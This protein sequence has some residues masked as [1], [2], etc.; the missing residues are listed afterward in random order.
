MLA[1]GNGSNTKATKTNDCSIFKNSY[2][3]NNTLF[4]RFGSLVDKQFAI[5]LGLMMMV[6]VGFGQTV[7]TGD[8]RTNASGATFNSA[9][10]W[11]YYNGS[12]WVTATSASKPAPAA[13]GGTAAASTTLATSGSITLNVSA[14]SSSSG[15]TQNSIASA[16]GS[17]SKIFLSAANANIVAGLPVTGTN[18]PANSYVTAYSSSDPSI[19]VSTTISTNT[20]TASTVLTFG[21]QLGGNTTIQLSTNAVTAG[22]LVGM[23][24]GGSSVANTSYVTAINVAGNPNCI[25][26]SSAPSN[27]GV[28]GANTLTCF[29]S[30]T[31]CTSICVASN[32]S[33]VAG[34]LV[35]GAN[36]PAGAKVVSTSGS[37]GVILSLP[38]FASNSSAS[39]VN[40]YTVVTPITNVFINHNTTIDASTTSLIS[41]LWINNTSDVY[42]SGSVPPSN[43]TLTIGTSTTPML[44]NLGT[45]N[46]ASSA[47]IVVNSG[48]VATHSMAINST[49]TPV[50]NAGSI[51]LY[52]A[53]NKKCQI[54]FAGSG[55]QTIS[56]TGTSLILSDL[57][58]ANG[59][60][61]VAPSTMNIAGTTFTNNGTFTHNSSS[62]TFS[63]AVTTFTGA[64][65]TFNNITI[66][67]GATFTH[68]SVG[69]SIIG[70]VVNNGTFSASSATTT[71]SGTTA[72]TTT[73]SPTFNFNSLL[74]SGSLTAYSGIM[75]ISGAFT[76]NGT[77]TNNSGTI[78]FTG[79]SANN[80]A[81]SMTGTNAFNNVNINASNTYT[82]TSAADINGNL[83][84]T[85]ASSI[86]KAPTSVLTLKGNLT[87]TTSGTFTHNS[88]TVTFSPSTTSIV[89]GGNFAFN[90]LNINS[91]TIT[92]N[93][94]T[95][96]A[97]VTTVASGATLA[98]S[99]G[100]TFTGGSSIAGS[101]QINS[102]GSLSSVPTYTGANSTLIYNTGGSYGTSNEW[103][104]GASAGVAVGAGIP[105]NVSIQTTGTVVTL[106]GGRGI[107]GT[108]TVNSSCGM[109]LNA[110]SGDLYIGGDLVNNGSTWTNNS[111]AVFF[112]GSGTQ[113]IHSGSGTQFFDYL[114]LN[115]TGTVRDSTTTNIQINTTSGN[116][117][118]LLN[119]GSLDLNGK[120]LTLANNGGNIYT[121]GSSRTITSNIAGGVLAITGTK[122][123]VN[124]SGVG[125]L[126][127]GSNLS[128]NLTSGLDFGSGLSTVNGTVNLLSGGYVN[129]N[130]PT[131]GSASTLA[132]NSGSSYGVGS[133]W[134]A[135]ALSGAGVPQNVTIGSTIASS[136]LNFGS[137]T[138]Y[139]QA[140]GNVTIS[141]AT[142]GSYLTLS[143]AGGGDLYVGGNFTNNGTFTHNSRGVNVNGSSNVTAQTISGTFNGSGATNCIPYLTINTTGSAGVTLGSPVNVTN[144]LTLTA[145]IV[146]TTASNILTVVGNSTTAIS[147][148]S[149]TAFVNGPLAWTAT[150][151]SGNYKFPIGQG[152]ST[153]NYYPITLGSPNTGGS[154]ITLTAESFSTGSATGG[155]VDGT[156]ASVNN[157]YWKLVSSSALT[158][159]GTVLLASNNVT[160]S[161]VVA[162]GNA[163]TYTTKGGSYSA[164]TVLSTGTLPTSTTQYYS[165]GLLPTFSMGSIV[166][167]AIAGV[168]QSNST[169]Y[170]GQTI[171]ISGFGFNSPT[172]TLTIGGVSISVNVTSNTSLTFVV[173][174]TVASGTLILSQSGT[175]LSQ[176]FSVLGYV[177]IA[178]GDWNTSSTWSADN[179]TSYIPVASSAVIVN[180]AV[181][182]TGTVTNAPS[183]I[184]IN[185]TKSLVFSSTGTLTTTTL[186]NN[187]TLTL[188]ASGTT[189]NIAAGGTLTNN[190]T[191]TSTAGLVNFLGAGTVNGSSATTFYNLTINT[192]TLTL[193][194]V[195]TINGTFTINGGSVSASPIYGAFSTLNYNVAYNRYLE[196]NAT[197]A[198]TIGTTAGYPNNV[199]ISTGTFGLAN[200]SGG[201]SRAL[202]GTLTVNSGCTFDMTGMSVSTTIAGGVSIAS[203]GT[204]TMSA[205]AGGDV[206]IGGNFSNSGTF[207]NNSRLVTLNGSS[208]QTVTGATTFAYLTISNA[209]GVS[210]ASSIIVNNTLILSS[211]AVS[212]NGQTINI[213]ASG[214]ITN[215]GGSL[216]TTG[217]GGADGGTINFVGAATLN[218]STATT[219]YNATLN[220]GALTISTVPTING[221]FTINGGNVTAAPKYASSSTLTYG[222]TYTRYLEWSATGIGIIGTTAGYPNNVTVASG[223]FTVVNGDAGTARA[224]AGSLS[225]ASGATFTTGALNAVFTVG[226]N[227]TTTGSGS[228]NLSS[229]S[230]PVTVVGSVNIS[231]TGALTLSSVSGG[232]LN[233]ATDWTN[234]GTFTSNGRTVSFNGA[235]NSTINSA[236]TFDYLTVSKSNGTAIVSL[237]A[238]CT[239]NQ[240]LTLTQGKLDYSTYTLTLAG[241][242]AVGT[243]T[244]VT[245]SAGNI[246]MT[247]N[248]NIPALTLGNL[249]IGGSSNTVTATGALTFATGT[250]LTVSTNN[251]LDMSTFTMAIGA[252]FTNSGTGTIQTKGI[253]PASQTWSG[254]VKYYTT[255]GGQ[256]VYSG[257]YNNLLLTNT[258]GTQT[259]NGAITV[260]G[261]LTTSS[262]G[263]FDMSTN[264]LTG[265]GSFA[266]TN[267]GTIKTSCLTATSSSP[268]P[269]VTYSSG[270]VTYSAATGAQTVVGTTYN[271]L[272]ISNTSGTQSAGGAIIVTGN[273]TLPTSTGTFDVTSANNYPISVAGNWVGSTAA[274]FTAQAGAVTFNGAGIQTISG[275]N[276][277][278]NLTDQVVAGTLKFTSGTTQTILNG[279]TL[280]LAGNGSSGN[281]N[282]LTVTSST[283]SSVANIT[284]AGTPITAISNCNISWI[285]NTSAA[286]TASSSTNSGNNTNI[287]FGNGLYWIGGTGT[288]AVGSF[289]T[290]SGGA[291]CG[292][293]PGAGDI[294]NFDVNSGS[295]PTITLSSALTVGALNFTNLNVTFAGAF[296]ITTT[297]MSVDGCHPTFVD[298][299][300]I[301]SSLTF[302]NSG[303]LYYAASGAGK[304]F[305]LG[306]GNSFTLTGNTTTSYFDGNTNSYWNYNT[307]SPLTLYFNPTTPTVGNFTVTKGNITLGN[308]LK[309]GRL[310]LS[311]TNSQQLI[312]SSGVTFTCTAG[313]T[314]SLATSGTANAGVI[315]ASASGST[316]AITGTNSTICGSA[317]TSYVLF[318]ANTIVNNFQLNNGGA[319]F[320][321]GLANGATTV[322]FNNLLLTAGIVNNST[323]NITIANNGTITRTAGT[324]SAAPIYG[325]TNSSDR[326]NVT[327]AGS[328]TTGLE[329]NGSNGSI[330]TF[331]VND[332]ITTTLLAGSSL[333]VDAV[334]VGGGTSGILTYP[335][336]TTVTGLTVN[337]AVTVNAG[338][339][340]TCGTQTS[341]VLHTLSVNGAIANAGTFDMTGNNANIANAVNVTLNGTSANQSIGGIGTTKFNTLTLNNSFSSPGA[342]LAGAVTINNVLALGSN[343]LTVGANTLTFGTT[344]SAP[345]LSSGGM[346]ASNGSAT[347]SFTNTSPITFPA[348]LFTSNV[349]NLTLNGI[350][351]VTLGS[352]TTVA[353]TLTVNA[354]NTLDCSTYQLIGGG[355]FAVTNSGTIKTSN[356][357]STPI[358][359]GYTYGGTVQFALTTGGQTIPSATYTNLTLSNASG[360]NT[361]NGTI[362]SSGTLTTTAGGTFDMTTYDLGVASITNNGTIITSSTSASPLTIGKTWAGTVTYASLS[363]GQTVSNGTYST[364][365]LNN[366]SGTNI[367]TSGAVNATTLTTTAGGTW[368]L[369]TAST[370][371][372]TLSSITNNGTIKTAV[373]TT[374]SATPIAIGKNYGAVGTIEF[375]GSAAQTLPTNSATYYY[376]LTINNTAANVT[377]TSGTTLTVNGVLTIST[378]AYLDVVTTTFA[379][380]AGFSNS[381]L[382]TLATQNTSASAA[383]PVGKT[384]YGNVL[385]NASTT[386]QSIVA[387]NYNNLDISGATTGNRTLINGATISISGNYT[388]PTGSG[389]MTTTGSTVIFNGNSAQTISNTATFNN[390]TINQ[391]THST[392]SL[393][394]NGTVTGTLTLT[395]GNV[396]T[397]ANTL[398]FT[399][400]SGGSSSAFV[401]GNLLRTVSSGTTYTFPVG[402]NTASKYYQTQLKPSFASGTTTINVNA[403][404]GATGSAQQG[405]SSNE[406]W[407]VTANNASS[408]VSL[409][410]LALQTPDLGTNGNIMNGTSLT[411][412]SYSL[413]GGTL[414]VS[415][416]TVTAT[417]PSAVSLTNGT[418]NYFV[419]TA[420][421]YYWVGGSGTW[422]SG[423]FSYTS[424][425]ASCAC[426]PTA[427]TDS[428]VFD[429]NSGTAPITV[430]M[431]S[432]LNFRGLNV[433]VTPAAGG[434]VIFSNP[435][436]TYYTIVDTNL[437]INNSQL[438]FVLNGPA[439]TGINVT[440][441]KNIN[442]QGSN[443]SLIYASSNNG[444]KLQFGDGTN[445]FNIT[446]PTSGA[447]GF[448][449][450][451]STGKAAINYSATNAQ[452]IYFNATRPVVYGIMVIK[453]NLILGSNVR[454]AS[455][456]LTSTNNQLLVV[457]SGVTLDLAATNTNAFTA[458]TNGGLID[459]RNGTVLI[460][461]SS[462]T[463]INNSANMFYT[464]VVDSLNLT[465]GTANT[466]VPLQALT[467]NKLALTTGNYNNTTNNISIPTNKTVTIDQGSFTAAPTYGSSVNL[468]YISSSGSSVTTNGNEIPATSSVLN[469][470]SVNA[471]GSSKTIILGAAPTI[472]GILTVNSGNTLDFSANALN[473]GNSATITN[474]GTIKTSNTSA[475]PIPAGITYGGTVQF[476]LA[477]GG[478]TIPVNN[479]NNLTFSNTSG[480]NTANGAITSSGTLT[481][482][483]GGTLDM[484]SYDLGVTTI[485]N[486]GT[487]KTSSTTATA[488]TSGKTWGGTVQFALTTGGQTIPTGAFNN[489]TLS[490]TS[491]TNTASGAITSSGTLTTTAGGTLEMS[492]YDLG[493]A[494][495][496]NNGTI[497]T[498]STSST[499]LTTGKSWGGTVQ[500]ASTSGGQTIALG[501]YTTLTLSNTSGTNTSSGGAVNATTLNTTAGG[502]WD[503]GSTGTLGGTL[504]S[505]THNG[506]LKS[507][508][509]STPIANNKTYGGTGTIEFN[510]TSAQVFTAS[511]S[512]QV[513]NLIV[514][515]TSGLTLT[516][517]LT[518]NGTLTIN[519]NC[520]FNLQSN[521][522]VAGSSFATSI[523]G[524]LQT[525]ASLPTGQTWGGTVQYNGATSNQSIVAGTYNN[526]DIS[527]G[528]TGNRTLVNGAT[529]TISGNYTANTGSG[530]LTTTGSTVVF[531]GSNA[532]SITNPTSFNNLTINK[533]GTA[534]ALT[535]NSRVNIGT[536][537]TGVL[538]LTS[539]RVLTTSINT[540]TLCDTI[541][542]TALVGG[543]SSAYIDGPFRRIARAGSTSYIFPVGN[544][545][546]GDNYFVDTLTSINITDTI[547]VT[548]VLSNSGSYDAS[549]T[550]IGNNEYWIVKS[551]LDNSVSMNFAPFSLGANNVM[552]NAS[553][554][555]GQYHSVGGVPTQTS[556]QVSGLVLRAGIDSFY[557]I[558]I[559]SIAAPSITLVSSCVPTTAANGFY[560][561]DT[562]TITGTGFIS[563]SVV[564]VG[565]K[566]ATVLVNSGVPTSLT[567]LVS[568]TAN[569]NVVTVSNLGGTASYDG[570]FVPGYA[571]RYAGGWATA[572]TWLGNAVPA[573]NAN[574]NICTAVTMGSTTSGLQILT[575]NSGAS[576]SCNNIG[577]NFI[578]GAVITNNGTITS[579]NTMTFAGTLTVAGSSNTQFS[580]ITLNALTTFTTAPLI[581]GTM[582]FNSGSSLAG[583]A[584]TYGVSSVI[585]YSQGGT[586]SPGLEWTA[587]ATSGAGVPYRVN[588]TNGTTLTLSSGIYKVL[589][590]L[591]AYGNI[592]STGGSLNLSASSMW[593][594]GSSAQTINIGTAQPNVY[595]ITMAN[596]AGV[597]LVSRVNVTNSFIFN[598]SGGILTPSDTLS[599]ASTASI[600]GY[601]SINYIN[602]PLTKAITN[603]TASVFPIGISGSYQPVTLTYATTPSA[604]EVVTITPSTTIPSGAPSTVSTVQ[605][606]TNSWNINQTVTGTAYKVGL[607]N[608]TANT[609]G[610]SVVIVRREGTGSY[611]TTS[612]TNVSSVYTNNSNLS[613]SNSSNDVFL[614]ESG[615]PLTVT[616]VVVNNKPYDGTTTATL[617]ST[618]TLS[619]ILVGDD[620]SL[621]SQSV[622]FSS[623]NV[624]TGI[625]MNTNF[626]TTGANAGAYSLSQPSLT[627]NITALSLTITANDASKNYGSSLT[628]TNSTAFTSSGLLSGETIG[629]VTLNYSGGGSANAAVGTF[630]IV[631][632][633]PVATSGAF[634]AGNYSISY[635][636]GTLTVVAGS[637]G[638]WMGIT[639]TDFSTPSN[640]ADGIVPAAGDNVIISSGASN[641]PVLSTNDTIGSLVYA[642]GTFLGLGGNTL[643]VNNEINGS[644]TIKST[645]SSSLVL[646]GTTGTV[647]FDANNDTIQNLT[648][649][650]GATVTLGSSLLIVGDA[651][652][653]LVTIGSGAILTTG[654]N[655]TLLS[656][657]LG[658]ASIG[659]IAGTISGNVTVQ[660]YISAKSVRKFSMVGSPV[661]QSIHNAWQQQVYITGAGSGGTICGAANSNGFDRTNTNS[662][663]MFTYNASKVN[664]SRWVSVANT[665][666]NMTPGIGY[667]MNIRGDRNV[668]SC[669]DQLTSNTPAPP[670]AVTLSATGKIDTGNVV[671]NL[672]TPTTH[673]YTLVANPY[674]STISFTNF[675]LGN[676]GNV[677][678]NMWSYSPFGNGNYTTYSSGTLVNGATGFDGVSGDYIA[679]GQAFFVQA[680]N[681]IAN[682]AAVTFNESHK[683]SNVV[684]NTRYFGTASNQLL[685]IGLNSTAN[686]R[687]DEIVVRFRGDGTS[688]YN[689]QI[690]AA[691]LNA[692]N[693]VLVALKGG[694]KVAIATLPQKIVNETAQL[695]VASTTSGTY[696][697]AFRD[698]EGLDKTT[699]IVLVDKFL[700]KTQDIRLNQQYD[701]NV[702]SDTAS[703]GNNRFEVIF[704][705]GST[706]P[707][708][709]TNV[710]A[711][712]NTEGVEVN[713]KVATEKSIAEYKVERSIDATNF[714]TIATTKATGA[715]SYTIE[716]GKPITATSYYRIKAIGNDGT[717]SYSQTAKLITHSSSFITIYPN[718]VQDKLNITLNNVIGGNYKI[719][720][721]SATGMEVIGKSEVTAIGN[722]ITLPANSLAGGVYVVELTDATGFKQLKN[723]VKQ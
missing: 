500:Y 540:L 224:M 209:A 709:F 198:G 34:Q 699:S 46:V 54:S 344:A 53:S 496:T 339:S 605:L 111:R 338:G 589:S 248:K 102:G 340:F 40:F 481:T 59:A 257:T 349:N 356:T 679:S 499:P 226:A 431:A 187:G 285:N 553:T 614:A 601:S 350:G 108:L 487:I 703:Q 170:Y 641:Y 294:V 550:S 395:N 576:L 314:C 493:V 281:S 630:N 497:K 695:G 574:I 138:T 287:S 546:S 192:G 470:L 181:S 280:T 490:N 11:D 307:T 433:S 104:G 421:T 7:T 126:I 517:T 49:G 680:A 676:T 474:S 203:T 319:T 124:N 47:S 85:G 640:W 535:L 683:I 68:S 254:T 388:A 73:A 586:P 684:P 597:T 145:G 267:G 694:N 451:S 558:G 355:S 434:G 557:V 509:T 157:E 337:G 485:T 208:L 331:R 118:Q 306:N 122:T 380:G 461:G 213:A 240:D 674:P 513:Y 448:G 15:F 663:S 402:S 720:I 373:P 221:T 700:N 268:I 452:T 570:T 446:N 424:G 299:V 606:G 483:S 173:P 295:T 61:V 507:Q 165:A 704:K 566:A 637:H 429:D 62:I 633:N 135:N 660:R 14:A 479:Y 399:T 227:L 658:T 519:S 216:A 445:A 169:G 96:M 705:G 391:A 467:V 498:S 688:S 579:A 594:N 531:T 374:T 197:G 343:T 94:T 228:V 315:D 37:N 568:S 562:L 612:A 39:A 238:N 371:G 303:Y 191:S 219:F 639:S 289:S 193:S 4:S 427:A 155:T 131:F 273:I 590:L 453:G 619:G 432:S 58:I 435:S 87:L 411:G 494:S 129:T 543:S 527:G 18:V 555:N 396:L 139:R 596:L 325:A 276:S 687:L 22:V 646:N 140:L 78:N 310:N 217:T 50:N 390:L 578:T 716:D 359:S 581:N 672:N 292:Y 302:S 412:S 362:T 130:P 713:W 80:I 116:V 669:T 113:R 114:C 345:T 693:Q 600:S 714:T 190:A 70:N 387:G 518:V 515:N 253:L 290:T 650:T 262:G 620:V 132:Y 283:G 67:S 708:N 482:T 44:I 717:S 341:A 692:G 510:G 333:S 554:A 447:I 270:T 65:T 142:A 436:A 92:I 117:L 334:T 462:S 161:N 175:D 718:P 284:F 74:I 691:S 413:V 698:Y 616:G 347:I 360:T 21:N 529:I 81:G 712:E 60:T 667:Q 26:I 103:N 328:V 195:P 245:A 401:D 311:S 624:G 239:A 604:S 184:T 501:T 416:N 645:S 36:I 381:G 523:A 611:S 250:T 82:I 375:Y 662:P 656:D 127:F 370:L 105:A 615:I 183:S 308:D 454:V 505:V 158:S 112:V 702:T 504:S 475:T 428:I 13:A 415:S 210:L 369:G 120:T 478:Q 275:S 556:I 301:N 602:G 492:T 31:T 567:V 701:F 469:N 511:G 167:T 204:L 312:I 232:D 6:F 595:S 42:P 559:T 397:G 502:T 207:T 288:W 5:V 17:G 351:G 532:Q 101:I 549:L 622:S 121:T 246:T 215:N 652:A 144:T 480:T 410:T 16:T 609:S 29:S 607:Y 242:I 484:A 134:K 168:S 661:T 324:L 522:L 707:V 654:G 565:G 220:T 465:I 214:T 408:A 2:M 542:G 623:Q 222:A 329:T 10:N 237:G 174:P 488:L 473:L 279:G 234:A 66:N 407:T 631:P 291:S 686:N 437:T 459:A 119:T 367:A 259:A 384:W 357:T 649:T 27:A 398:T 51:N 514:S 151:S 182:V 260:N 495:I 162:Y 106:A 657:S 512:T 392:V 323:N 147:G 569:S 159:L 444:N 463:V 671:V 593:F 57:L 269:A 471:S 251:T 348:S 572:A 75:T 644:G 265:G 128:I 264:R 143:T 651:N 335:N 358:P 456:N 150:T 271:N 79:T 309:A 477:T 455:I 711:T 164:G 648:L 588:V 353:K 580:S 154:S 506:L 304:N 48:A 45:L 364:L 263:T 286:I 715:N 282:F 561:R 417:N 153:T 584:P 403:T 313:G 577:M 573:S 526:L 655:L 719:R 172:P 533:S 525:Q 171:T 115:N 23:P 63:G 43:P 664:N 610:G 321:V 298:I 97:G 233:V 177:S 636:N 205:T 163:S 629:T 244:I 123:V 503:M 414:S 35:V 653:G 668:G 64:T 20:I 125:T 24:I 638:Q 582:T 617:A 520:T 420:P 199:T 71:F 665:S 489:L 425:G 516:N 673:L 406:Y 368:D 634:I 354:S 383:I 296:V 206:T 277:F 137:G 256:T 318:K 689:P 404:N 186:T 109:I 201:T 361:A 107:P 632:S 152:V 394:A 83:G 229:T 385:F 378:G 261:T 110:T 647:S 272:T 231:I 8:Y 76:N 379:A 12:S 491:G 608:A 179:S 91:G 274:N 440:I 316:F 659:Q 180:N 72:L 56:N 211:G 697:L 706:L 249:I 537:T 571:S 95:T 218:G 563:T 681:P 322:I 212:L 613:T 439:T 545:I 626:L 178:D 32:T 352:A 300:T 541:P 666:G 678:N 382:G 585:A 635:V 560:A 430:T 166:P 592:N 564:T 583:N 405:I 98:T 722:T 28:K 194:T 241:N 643:T 77:F 330:G 156:L 422:G 30:N 93:N 84:I 200:G 230:Q 551:V 365:N 99:V 539:G 696:R 372:G 575:V 52:N 258:S 293:L 25:T 521:T 243:G 472:N 441:G 442:F 346:D 235:G 90:T 685:R 149:N 443:D 419:L 278:Y 188:G 327:Y 450:Q 544:Y 591:A 621:S 377:A 418:P 376:N 548:A 69:I 89:S 682:S 530:T 176:S 458:S 400:I 508:N 460:S 552:A 618:G 9:T 386:N 255:A 366:T 320:Y 223:T 534:N 55:S 332:G 723:F 547:S 33:V 317:G 160:A 625:A 336:S 628:G 136:G 438:A 524:I 19:T 297:S 449:D 690:D 468:S 146:T 670:T 675:Y 466:F 528:T 627:A 642:S 393:S 476:A 236:T 409:T 326:V 486:G 536:L 148:G 141:N 538:T 189:L 721:L 3:K 710:T 457:P 196:W 426:I 185:S 41:N 86:L 38:A 603:T 423:A 202:A 677:N 587:S 247:G 252:S 225:V 305:T 599:L 389:T 88:G 133:E 363:G 266:V 1:L 342:T 464:G 598:T 100:L